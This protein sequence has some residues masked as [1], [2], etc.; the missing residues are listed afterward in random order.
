MNNSEA[1][2]EYMARSDPKVKSSPPSIVRI[3][4]TSD[5]LTV[6]EFRRG[7]KRDKPHYEDLK[8]DKIFNTWNRGFVTKSY[9]PYAF[10]FG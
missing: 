9:A 6:Q 3:S 5:E 10:G 2:R 7:V 1:Y 8:D 4:F